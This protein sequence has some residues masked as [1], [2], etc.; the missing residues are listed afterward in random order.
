MKTTKGFMDENNIEF[1]G[2]KFH[3]AAAYFEFM[4][5]ELGFPNIL[6][7]FESKKIATQGGIKLN[8][9]V[10]F[11]S[12]DAPTIVFVPGTSVYGLCFAEI[13]YLIG[14]EGYN[15][16]SLD[17]RGH[18]RSQGK[19]GD[20][21]IEELMLDVRTTIKYAKENF[22]NKVSLFGNSQGG[23]VS[24]YLA[25]EDIEVDSVICQNFADL[26]WE[27]TYKLARFP[28]LAKLSKPFISGIGKIIPHFTVSTLTYLDLKKIKI[29]YFGT[30]H[31]FIQDDPFTISRISMRAAR[32]LIK[33]KMKKSVEEITI[34]IFVFQG[35]ADR[36]FPVEYTKSLYARIT[37]KKKIKIYKDCDHAIMVENEN[38]ILPDILAWLQEIYPKKIT[39]K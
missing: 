10:H 37:S 15:I 29:K 23:I 36:I 4:I 25:A 7:F 9:D 35:D 19:R 18:G 12:K 39:S 24:F 34:P 17:P 1:K 33:A 26:A 20:Y 28:L 21:T 6:H 32:S 11:H 2:K 27:D 8:I 30:L 16:V 22:N 31:D 38:L 5:H 14:K 13:L 3:S